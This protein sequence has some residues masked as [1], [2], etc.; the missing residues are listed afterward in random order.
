MAIDWEGGGEQLCVRRGGM[1]RF[2]CARRAGYAI[3]IGVVMPRAVR[4]AAEA[5]LAVDS[6]A[7]LQGMLIGFVRAGGLRGFGLE[8]RK[9]LGR[10]SR[11][12]NVLHAKTKLYDCGGSCG[13]NSWKWLSRKAPACCRWSKLPLEPRSELGV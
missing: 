2:R 8:L 12:C 1:R 5:A 3:S 10:I 7:D 4:A 9:H 13:E 11:A 6:S